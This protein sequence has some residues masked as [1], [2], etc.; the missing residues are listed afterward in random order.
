MG[1]APDCLLTL[2][3]QEE[4]TVSLRLTYYANHNGNEATNIVVHIMQI[5]R[6]CETKPV[7]AM[8]R[9]SVTVSPSLCLPSVAVKYLV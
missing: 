8:D 2:V 3:V 9:N 5:V 6:H 4:H 7:M 1:G